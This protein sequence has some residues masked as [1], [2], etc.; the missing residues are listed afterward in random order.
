MT[1]SAIGTNGPDLRSTVK[2]KYG[3]A[4]LRVSEGAIDVS[5]CGTSAC[6][7]STTEAWDPITS[8]LYDEKQKAGIPAEALLASLGCGNPTALAEL[9]EGETVLDLGSGGGIDV[10]LSAKR[11]G[12][13]GK[14]YGLDMTDEMLA[15]ANENK[16]RAGV[17][18][19]EFLKGE[20]ERIPLPDASV[21]VIISNC[22]I[23]L[24]GDKKKVLAEAFRVLKPGG[25]F[26][27]SDVVV[28]GDV[29]PAV[30]SSMELW[31]GCVAGALEEQEFLNLLRQVGFENPSIEPTRVYK[32]Q[33]ALAFLAGTGLDATE[34]A[35]QIDGKFMGAFVRA[36]K[37]ND[38]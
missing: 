4:A 18:N 34:L 23:N 1:Q 14:A 5:C 17:D 13:T 38:V 25:R 24:S 7:G 11:V 3:Q 26:A 15:L 30:R 6:C 35:S 27:V 28:R 9:A 16:R 37:P 29:P 33:D 12:P 32:A 20:I 19:I 31:I 8:D 2:E 10:L 21:D 22:V 36:S